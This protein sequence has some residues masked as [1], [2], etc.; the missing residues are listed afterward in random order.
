MFKMD[1]ITSIREGTAV[2][3]SS[4]DSAPVEIGERSD[5]ND[6]EDKDD[7]K[8]TTKEKF[9]FWEKISDEI[10]SIL[11]NGT[12]KYVAVVLIVNQNAGLVTVT[13]MKSQ[14]NWGGTLCNDNVPPQ[15]D[16]VIRQSLEPQ[17]VDGPEPRRLPG[18][19]EAEEDPDD[20]GEPR[21]QRD[22]PGRHGRG[23]RQ[24]FRHAPRRSHPQEDPQDV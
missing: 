21:R 20:A 6:S 16:I 23:P 8:I 1:Y 12:E 14:Y 3:K 11:N 4:V 10:T 9:D 24:K 22:G 5:N 15:P 2:T 7:N 18:R 19:I 17:G 13:G